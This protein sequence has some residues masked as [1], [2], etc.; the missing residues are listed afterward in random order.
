MLSYYDT[1]VLQ[2]AKTQTDI[3]NVPADLF[4]L[5][6]SCPDIKDAK[7]ETIAICVDFDDVL[8]V[9]HHGDTP[10]RKL[11]TDK[12]WPY[13]LSASNP[14]MT[15]LIFNTLALE[16]R[17]FLLNASNRVESPESSWQRKDW[18][19][20]C[21]QIFGS[22]R[23]FLTSAQSNAIFAA[24]T[25]IFAAPGFKR[26]GK[27]HTLSVIKNLFNASRRILIDDLEENTK[28]AILCGHEAIHV[29]R[30]TR[31]AGSYS[32]NPFLFALVL[33]IWPTLSAAELHSKFAKAT[34][35][36]DLLAEFDKEITTA[37]AARNEKHKDQRFLL[38][39]SKA[40]LEHR[41]KACLFFLERFQLLNIDK[42]IIVLK[43]IAKCLW[44]QLNTY[45]VELKT[46]M[47]LFSHDVL[48]GSDENFQK[49][50]VF[51]N[52]WHEFSYTVELLNK[53]G[54]V[55]V[56]IIKNYATTLTTYGNEFFNY[57]AARKSYSELLNKCWRKLT[58]KGSN[59]SH[60]ETFLADK[61]R[62]NAAQIK[63]MNTFL[64]QDPA[65]RTET[66][67]DMLCT[68]TFY[69]SSEPMHP[70]AEHKKRGR[71]EDEKIERVRKV[72]NVRTDSFVPAHSS[73]SS[74]SSSSAPRL[75]RHQ[76]PE[77]TDSIA[78]SLGHTCLPPPRTA[79]TPHVAP[80]AAA[81]SSS[82]SSSCQLVLLTT[83]AA[84]PPK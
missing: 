69:N 30:V 39:D 25:P 33:R 62:V 14:K 1:L 12:E 20:A 32:N 2:V 45:I 75:A 46:I 44:E 76:P 53:H 73:S 59:Q 70:Q 26:W 68:L 4:D 65:S 84:P 72:S 56:P 77:G 40:S 34:S 7:D 31:D 36:A 57:I 79:H 63:V 67:L 78:A 29:P 81:A 9:H 51:L 74:S 13:P 71:P 38:E 83:P 58:P 3:E 54:V 19:T 37:I 41:T 48:L 60:Q 50:C 6:V 61:A 47:E 10:L 80:A 24:L 18:E 52:K 8:N 82:S 42:D 11:S 66:T 21:D 15:C 55:G 22:E 49:F 5:L 17:V 16:P 64:T 43:L 23:S 28:P 35:S 27:E